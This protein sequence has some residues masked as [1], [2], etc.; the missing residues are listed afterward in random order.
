MATTPNPND[1][2]TVD[3]RVVKL[4]SKDGDE[5]E[6]SAKAAKLSALIKTS[7]ECDEEDEDEDDQEPIVVDML[8]VE[9]SCLE[10]VV[11]FLEHHS[12]DPMDAIETPLNGNTLDEVV[13]QEWYRN[14]IG[15]PQ[16]MVFELVT[17]ANYM[18][19]Q[20]LLDLAC[21]RVSVELMGKTAEEIRV[22]LNIPKMTPEE[23]KKARQEHKW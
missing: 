2:E 9:S 21:L 11:E 20:S 1:C 5:F 17:A 15:V 7:I 4:R 22:M 18:E 23:E 10:K 16:S 3:E 8:K 13:K 12:E 14:F 19:I 6:L